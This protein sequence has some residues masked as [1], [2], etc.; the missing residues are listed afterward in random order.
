M[1]QATSPTRITITGD[2]GSGKSTF[3]RNVAEKL[4]CQLITTGNM[5][6]ELAAKKGITV[7]ELNQ[8]A[9]SKK[10]IDDYVDNFLRDLNNNKEDLILDSRMAWHF[11][12]DA[13]KVRLSVDPEI[14][15]DRISS[16]DQTPL[17]EKF[18]DLATA[19]QQVVDRKASEVTR[20][21]RVYGVDISCAENFDLVIDTSLISPH[22]VMDVFR[23]SFERYQKKL[24]TPSLWV[25]PRLILPQ[26]MADPS[27]N[28]FNFEDMV[29]APIRAI[30]NGSKLICLGDDALLAG[31]ITH[32][33]PL[34]AVQIAHENPTPL[35]FDLI[36]DWENRYH[37]IFPVH[38]KKQVE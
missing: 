18:P 34:V 28:Q 12:Q 19:T 33:T 25:S 4:G 11:V 14:A 21:A 36:D 29:K 13:F 24:Q 15:I 20:Y 3:A 38:M 26:K 16:D 31:A 5:F 8:L 9:E 23:F 35:N 27:A 32:G 1:A 7:T 22:D 6:R 2:P 37:F 17:R 10:E 30:R